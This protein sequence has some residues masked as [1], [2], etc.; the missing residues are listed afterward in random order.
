M[1]TTI[2]PGD[3]DLANMSQDQLQKEAAKVAGETYSY[4]DPAAIRGR[5]QG[6]SAKLRGEALGI[7]SAAADQ[8]TNKMALMA[9]GAESVKRDVIGMEDKMQT[10][11]LQNRMEA[12]K[13]A[14][15]SKRQGLADFNAAMS[16]INAMR[17]E[18][19]GFGGWMTDNEQREFQA[20]VLAQ[21][22][23]MTEEQKQQVFDANDEYLT[24]DLGGQYN[25][26]DWF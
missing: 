12:I 14:D 9:E 25:L 1:A 13:A 21:T 6:A 24:A 8:G 3:D 17:A 5:A 20:Y 26:D 2:N 23:N 22:A 11:G 19:E 4:F 18:K 16:N 10:E 15:E 7:A